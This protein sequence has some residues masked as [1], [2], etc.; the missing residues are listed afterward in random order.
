MCLENKST[1]LAH[2]A[3]AEKRCVNVLVRRAGQENTTFDGESDQ[4]AETA[5]AEAQKRPNQRSSPWSE[6]KSFGL[7]VA[8]LQCGLVSPCNQDKTDSKIPARGERR[9]IRSSF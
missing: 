6:S 4:Q 7:A 8:D 2:Q 9:L 1:D 3:M 5:A